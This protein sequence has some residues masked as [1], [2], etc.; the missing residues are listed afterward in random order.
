MS[1]ARQELE[2]FKFDSDCGGDSD[3]SS[4]SNRVGSDDGSA[5][6]D[7]WSK[8]A[9]ESVALCSDRNKEAGVEL[10]GKP[11]PSLA[12]CLGANGR[13]ALQHAVEDASKFLETSPL[14]RLS[15]HG[16][17]ASLEVVSQGRQHAETLA[18]VLA[19]ATAVQTAAMEWRAE[20][21]ALWKALRELEAALGDPPPTVRSTTS[22]SSSSSGTSGSENNSGNSNGHGGSS[23]RGSISGLFGPK[24]SS[25]QPRRPRTESN[26]AASARQAAAEVRSWLMSAPLKRH[27]LQAQSLRRRP[28]EKALNR[29]EALVAAATA[30]GGH[31]Q[32]KRATLEVWSTQLRTSSQAAEGAATLGTQARAAAADVQRTAAGLFGATGKDAGSDS[33]SSPKNHDN[34][35]R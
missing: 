4:S 7:V 9:A 10:E 13:A 3:S 12:F 17:S 5:S 16:L 14:E 6:A 18:S 22:S 8:L 26:T 28:G 33:N 31:A 27:P 30:V 29:D 2:D 19:P 32:Q 15:T 24:G 20:Q 11:P 23:G 35:N 25:V 34:T 21:V 1:V